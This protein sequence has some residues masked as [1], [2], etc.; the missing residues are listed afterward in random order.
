LVNLASSILLVLI[1][2]VTS[3]CAPRHLGNAETDEASSIEGDN[4][5]DGYHI[6]E[7]EKSYGTVVLAPYNIAEYANADLVFEGVIESVS[8]YE[9]R[10]YLS[11]DVRGTEFDRLHTQSGFYTSY[12]TIIKVRIDEV[13]GGSGHVKG[14]KVALFCPSGNDTE[15]Y[16]GASIALGQRAVFF[17]WEY[18]D[19]ITEFVKTHN[20][21]GTNFES[22]SAM[23]LPGSLYAL[24][25]MNED[26]YVVA[27]EEW[28]D[29]AAPS[30]TM[31]EEQQQQYNQGILSNPD[32]EGG[33]KSY[34]TRE[35]FKR[36]IRDLRDKYPP[37][38]YERS[39]WNV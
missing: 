38:S 28:Q 5:V 35:D 36:A 25:P 1:L 37:G 21:A 15:A 17:V 39:W 29:E 9:S 12:K 2:C 30:M 3:A 31:S 22:E 14:D 18:S 10:D 13:Y 32:K 8:S 11:E 4:G 26:G 6:K 19:A 34:Y 24:F 23:F 33:D 27:L 20:Y 16:N 7:P